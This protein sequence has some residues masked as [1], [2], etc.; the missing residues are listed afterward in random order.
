[1]A[2]MIMSSRQNGKTMSEVFES[3]T[4]SDNKDT[5]RILNAITRDAYSS[6]WTK[7]GSKG[8]Q[9]NEIIEFA[10]EIFSSCID[11]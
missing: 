8:N 7:W 11:Q 4:Q 1:M 6:D 10:N 5:V 3:N 2:K 9:E